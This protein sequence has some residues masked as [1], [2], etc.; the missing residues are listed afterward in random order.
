LRRTS[1]LLAIVAGSQLGHTL[2]YSAKYGA[3]VARYQSSGVHAYLPT[4]TASIGAALGVVLMTGLLIVAAARW[5][6]PAPAGLRR[7]ST[8][9][10]LDVL[11]MA[12]IAQLIIFISQETIEALAAGQAAPSLTDLLL[13]GAFGQLPAAVVAAAVITWLLTRLEAAWSAL[14]EAVPR[15]LTEPFTP[16]GA[17][18][19]RLA[20][21]GRARLGSAFPAAFRKR[22]PPLRLALI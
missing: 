10:F 5:M 6:V 19:T 14:A 20:G 7:R 8:M 3:A 11:A 9:R 2:V 12:F 17:P 18:E 16:D 15:L 13:W 1:A 21:D 4:L 22:G